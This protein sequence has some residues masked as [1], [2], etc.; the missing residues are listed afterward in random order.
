M[1]FSKSIYLLRLPAECVPDRKTTMRRI[2][3]AMLLSAVW[4]TAMADVAA[5]A[6]AYKRGD[7]ATALREW[8][9]LA[10]QGDANAQYNLGV[11]YRNGE[12]VPEDDRQAAFWY[13]KAAEQGDASAQNNLGLMYVA[14]ARASPRTTAKPRFGSG[15]RPSRETTAPSTTWG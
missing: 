8:R 13:R 12:G 9:P 5:G 11:M 14:T 15:K 6:Q 2:I 3:A 1:C 10:E 4:S 7:Y